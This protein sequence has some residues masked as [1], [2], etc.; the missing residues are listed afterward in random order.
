[1]RQIGEELRG[2]KE[3]LGKLVRMDANKSIHTVYN[4]QSYNDYFS[5]IA[6]FRKWQ[7][8]C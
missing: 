6:F 7:N 3:N 2:H 4:I 5:V 1:M 8:L